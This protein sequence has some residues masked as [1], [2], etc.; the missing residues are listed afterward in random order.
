MHCGN[1]T[2]ADGI[3]DLALN[4]TAKQKECMKDNC[5][6]I[7]NSGQENSDGDERGSEFD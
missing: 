6:F 4:C 2:D 1:D 3:P 7:P 5:M